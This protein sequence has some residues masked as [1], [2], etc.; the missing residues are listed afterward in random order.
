MDLPLLI[1]DTLT[2][3]VYLAVGALLTLTLYQFTNRVHFIKPRLLKLDVIDRA[4]PLV[5]KTVWLYF[6]EYIIFLACYFGLSDWIN[7]TRYFYAY[8]FLLLVSCF[9]FTVYPVTFPR[10]DYKLDNFPDSLSKRALQY[11]RDNMDTPANCLPSLHVSSC[12][13]SAFAFWYESKTLFWIFMVWSA[14]VSVSTLTTKQHYFIDIWTAFLLT[15]ASFYIFFIHA[16]Y[17][18]I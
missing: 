3:W 10:D 18:S 7:M 13:I 12:F 2:S 9:I 11:L 17:Y 8:V 16:T 4:V 6:S 5:P 15:L 14:L 1:H